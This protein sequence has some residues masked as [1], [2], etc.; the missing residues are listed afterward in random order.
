MKRQD[1]NERFRRKL[2]ISGYSAQTVKS[3]QS[4]INKFLDYLQ[5]NEVKEVTSKEISS[6]LYNCK[7]LGY[8]NSSM[9]LFV[10]AIRYLYENVLLEAV[11][12]SLNI[13]FRKSQSLPTV[14]SR[15][16]IKKL[17]NVT[18][19]LKHKAILLTIYASGLRLGEVINLKVN[20]ID[21]E[22][23]RIHIHKGKGNKDRYVMLSAKLLSILRQYFVVYKPKKYLFEGQKRDQYSA[24]SVQSILK[25][26]LAKANINKKATVHT[27][28]HSFAT[29]LLDDGN[30]IRYIQELLGHKRIETTQIYTHISSHSINKIKSP[31]D[32]LDI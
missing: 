18:N 16:D 28:R 17:I 4:A 10:A 30:D 3:Y 23:M 29:H 13:K 9:K 19:N 27:L 21:S 22:A 25:Q 24:K 32:L 11:P 8:S 5:F 14:L 6:F 7:Q 31:A 20:D 2:E 15:N 12:D 1:L 26:A